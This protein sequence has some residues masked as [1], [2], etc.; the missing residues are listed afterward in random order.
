MAE[1]I[2]TQNPDFIR[3]NGQSVFVD[4]KDFT[5]DGTNAPT[6][7]GEAFLDATASARRAPRSTTSASSPRRAEPATHRP[8]LNTPQCLIRVLLVPNVQLFEGS[9]G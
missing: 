1:G 7:A 4:Y 5:G 8:D 2:D 6:T 9:G 3:P